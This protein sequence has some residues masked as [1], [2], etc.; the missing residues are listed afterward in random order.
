MNSQTAE[1][2]YVGGIHIIGSSKRRPIIHVS[3]ASR[4]T[5]TT[6]GVSRE[7]S[8]SDALK[9]M[10]SQ[11]KAAEDE[12]AQAISKAKQHNPSDQ[13]TPCSK[14]E[15]KTHDS[16]RDK[17]AALV[18][19]AEREASSSCSASSV[20]AEVGSLSGKPPPFMSTVPVQLVLDAETRNVE[21]GGGG[22]KD[23]DPPEKPNRGNGKGGA[24]YPFAIYVWNIVLGCFALSFLVFI[25]INST[26]AR[27]ALD[28]VKLKIAALTDDIAFGAKRFEVFSGRVTQVESGTASNTKNLQS[29]QSEVAGTMDSLKVTQG[30]LKV[31]ESSVIDPTVIA[32][33]ATDVAHIHNDVNSLKRG[34]VR[35]N[36]EI[37][38][39]KK[40]DAEKGAAIEMLK[41]AVATLKPKEES[42]QSGSKGVTAPQKG[43]FRL[44]SMTYMDGGGSAMTARYPKAVEKPV[45]SEPV[46]KPPQYDG[47]ET[48]FARLKRLRSTF[49]P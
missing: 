39:L 14:G 35:T 19:E 33:N 2:V 32:K 29:L 36:K 41:D 46:I 40:A 18:K 31:L 5:P 22:G 20:K 17:V 8:R 37:E 48:G 16:V 1:G 7:T 9:E 43:Q 21:S 13:G 47:N 42:N 30:R 45:L 24:H 49:K 12:T 26:K 38:E 11:K 28:E 34:N 10:S 44:S 4:T 23:T 15:Q 27:D 3:P 6:V 25:F